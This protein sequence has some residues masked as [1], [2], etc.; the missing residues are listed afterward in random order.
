MSL[1]ITG[2]QPLDTSELNQLDTAG[3]TPLDTSGLTAINDPLEPLLL[4]SQRS[5]EQGNTFTH[6][7]GSISSVL[8]GS[9]EDERLNDGRP[10]L[11]PFLWEGKILDKPGE[12]VERA[13]ASGA[14]WPSFESNDAATEASKRLSASFTE[15]VEASDNIPGRSQLDIKATNTLAGFDALDV[16]IPVRPARQE[17]KGRPKAMGQQLVLG[18]GGTLAGIPKN[19]AMKMAPDPDI[20]LNF[21][22]ID[23]N[24]PIRHTQPMYDPGGLLLPDPLALIY[25]EYEKASLTSRQEIRAEFT[26]ATVAA[27]KSALYQVGSDLDKALAERFRVDEKFQDDFLVKTS[28]AFGSA[29]TFVAASMVGRGI[30]GKGAMGNFGVP[31]LLGAQVNASAQFE[32]ALNSGADIATALKASQIAEVAGL[33]EAA[34]I[35]RLFTRLDKITGGQV[36]RYLARAV[37]QGTEEALQEA[38]MGIVQ[39][40]IANQMYDPERGIW[41]MERAEEA[42]IGFTTGA[43]LETLFSLI[44]PGRRR[45]SVSRATTGAETSTVEEVTEFAKSRLN[46]LADKVELTEDEQAAQSFLTENQTKP[47]VIAEAYG[48]TLQPVGKREQARVDTPPLTQEDIDSPIPNDLIEEGRAD[49]EDALGQQSAQNILDQAGFPEIGSQVQVSGRSATVVDAFDQD[50][51]QGAKLQYEDGRTTAESFESLRGRVSPTEVQD[52]QAEQAESSQDTAEDTTAQAAA[53]TREE[54]GPETAAAPRAA[55]QPQEVLTPGA[56]LTNGFRQG[57]AEGERF[58]VTE[59]VGATGSMTLE[60]RNDNVGTASTFH[61]GNDGNLI[62]GDTVILN[63]PE[64]LERL[65]QPENDAD[66]AAAS[67]ALNEMGILDVRDPRRAELGQQLKDIVLGKRRP[68]TAGPALDVE[69][70]TPVETPRSATSAPREYYEGD[71]Q[72]IAH[73][74]KAAE[75]AAIEAAATEMATRVS[76]SDTLVPIPSSTGTAKATLRL[77]EAIAA[78]SGA[79]AID[80]LESDPTAGQYE[81]KKA[82]GEPL[83]TTQ[84]GTRLKGDRPKGR[85]LLVDNVLATGNTMEAAKAAVGGQSEPL[86]FAKDSTAQEVK[87]AP[88]VTSDL[89]TQVDEKPEVAPSG[90]RVRWGNRVHAVDSFEDATRKWNLFRAATNLG[91]SELPRAEVI[92]VDGDVVANIAYNGKI[93]PVKAAKPAP[94][95]ADEIRSQMDDGG[96]LTDAEAEE[97]EPLEAAEYTQKLRDSGL[98]G[99]ALVA[100]VEDIHESW[101]QTRIAAPRDNWTDP[102]PQKEID[103]SNAAIDKL[104]IQGDERAFELVK[105]QD[106]WVNA[107]AIIVK[108]SDPKF[109]HRKNT[110]GRVSKGYTITT[111][112][113][114]VDIAGTSWTVPAD[115][116]TFKT[117]EGQARFD[118]M[119]EVFDGIQG[120]LPPGD[121]KPATKAAKQLPKKDDAGAARS[122]KTKKTAQQIEDF[123]E[124]IGGARKDL[125]GGFLDKLGTDLPPAAQIVMSK[126][127]PAPNYAKLAADGVPVKELALVKAMRDVIP[128]KPRRV[129]QQTSWGKQVEMLR[130]FARNIIEGKFT[131]DLVANKLVD[132]GTRGLVD[133]KNTMDLYLAAGFPATKIDLKGVRLRS[134]SYSQLRG[135]HY[136]PSKT[137]W[138]IERKSKGSAFGNWPRVLGDYYESRADLMEAA[139]GIFEAMAAKEGP[140]K[141]R[142]KTKLDIYRVT[143]TGKVWIGK[144]VAAGKYIDLKGFEKAQHAREYL[145]EHEDELLELLEKKKHI[146]PIRRSVNDPRIGVDHREGKDVTPE[147]FQET[148]GFRGVEFGNWVEQGKRQVEKDGGRFSLKPGDFDPKRAKRAAKSVPDRQSSLFIDEAIFRFQDKFNYLY[149]AQKAVAAKTGA[150]QVPEAE[151]AYLA[152]LRYHGIAGAAIEDFQRDYVEPLVEEISKSGLAIEDVESYLHARHA[153]E[154]NAQLKRINPDRENNEALSGMSD[155]EAGEIIGAVDDAGQ[156][157]QLEVLA[158]MIDS[159]TQ[160]QRKL[161]VES[162]LETAKAIAKWEETYDYYVPLHREGFAGLPPQR[163]KGFSVTGRQKRRAGSQR[164]VTNIL[165][166]VIAQQEATIIRAEKNKVSQA[167]L[168]FAKNNPNADLY[169]VDKVE[170]KPSFDS[171]GLVTYKPHRG[172]QFAENVLVVKVEGK[173]H[174][175]T[176]N[177]RN[178]QAM[179]IAYALKNLSAGHSGPI[180]NVLSRLM[181]YLAIINTGAN[182]EFIISNFARDIQTAGYNLSSTEADALKWT[183]IKDVG[184]AWRGIRAFQKKKSHPWAK[185]FDAFRKAGAQTGWLGL[186][187]DIAQ[188]EQR[189]RNMV[190]ELRG[191]APLL[192]VK[193]AIRGLITFIEDE[194]TA[195]ENG[196]RLS[197]FVHARRAGLSD[198]KAARI[199]KELTVNFNRKGDYGQV[200]N[201]L[202]LFYNASI[203]GSARVIIAAHKSPKV[204]K[205][206]GAT[207]VFAMFLDLLNRELSGDDDDGKNRYDKVADH[208]KER[209]LIIMLPDGKGDYIKIPL[210]W[211]YNVFHVM[212]SVMGEALT[213][214]NFRASAGAARVASSVFG[215]FNPIGGESSIAQAISPTVTD[216]IVQWGENKDWAGRPLR[217]EGNPFDVPQPESQQ[218]WNSVREPTRWITEKLN[219]LTGGSELRSGT[220]DINPEMI[221]L[222]IDTFTGGAGRFVADTFSTPIKAIKGEE[223]EI[224]E[225]PLLRKLYG[226]PGLGTLYQEYYRNADAVRVTE[227]EAKHYL[228]MGDH[229]ALAKLKRERRGEYDLINARRKTASQLTKARKQR[230]KIEASDL[231]EREKKAQLEAVGKDIKDLMNRFNRL[232]NQKVLDE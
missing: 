5:V 119:Q 200:M 171:E 96:T 7:D 121:A 2:L 181:R 230:K 206:I 169:A 28:G 19:L 99:D 34:P 67:K 3:L 41:T 162:G 57:P 140:K 209:N 55:E 45:G 146:P 129:W 43:L 42:A 85:I 163:G 112:G 117:P 84:I 109:A 31:A 106:H 89:A 219:E 139:P 72:D 196:I 149:K 118:R 94:S 48:T 74:L 66:S 173:D 60:K 138:T 39:A 4:H 208:V 161:M 17:N 86:V 93:R 49:L 204:R 53:T 158:G 205:L 231:S 26:Q 133:I 175:I 116:L 120:T 52:V 229:T 78:K 160:A 177:E 113:V 35:G 148:F 80:V 73:K 203:Q 225:I 47:N 199:A 207:I 179:R 182:P 127:F 24:Q 128:N 156:L 83:T 110:W 98:P 157:P 193:R 132:T 178:H 104:A 23:N 61:V 145:A 69:G 172:F 58:R 170:F 64:T 1:N 213:K 232:Y 215:A 82:G 168:E 123:G 54:G 166:H 32:D 81:T 144:K 37:Q 184:K 44:L 216:P 189:L 68:G 151:D 14:K 105:N 195:V 227:K 164:E 87:P 150:E 147:L 63:K 101:R 165:S 131:A 76:E 135:E 62:D 25:E 11:I 211:G 143:A 194:N 152:E 159:I 79:T 92:D 108:S 198:A 75:A 9:V 142:G 27:M 130:D 186:Y 40:G 212:G 46:V 114:S 33:S 91:A 50:G 223:I 221:D 153:P 97:L 154:A 197:A 155:E 56:E 126:H 10:T 21:D 111:S 30:F 51:L 167:M 38:F 8:S 13:I 180:V 124:K 125:W 20:L 15:S 222:L 134:A 70:L 188:R 201:A 190:E 18:A 6:P 141:G 136:D 59:R 100:D 77:A 192:K 90:L 12:A 71:T 122:T 228:D 176:F 191:G 187:G 65:W 95:R 88:A 218:Y 16:G 185:E 137:F 224:Y 102:L 29:L 174:T 202:Y 103:A 220:V 183:I 36:K 217:P 226:R 214:K 210:P 107:E 115:T 22:R